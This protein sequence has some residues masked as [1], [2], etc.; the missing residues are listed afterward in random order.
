MKKFTLLVTLTLCTCW[1]NRAGAINVN[2]GSGGSYSGGDGSSTSP[3]FIED[4]DDLK[5]LSET[6]DDW[7]KYFVQTADIDASE[8]A[9]STYNSGKGFSPIGTDDSSPFSGSYNGKGHTVSNLYIN[10]PTTDFIG[11]FG[12][13]T[14]GKICNLGVKNSVIS[15]KQCVGALAGKIEDGAIIDSCYSSGSLKSTYIQC[16]GLVGFAAGSDAMGEC[17]IKNSYSTATVETTNRAGGFIGHCGCIVINCY[18]TGNAAASVDY[19]GG[20][21]GFA[22]G[23][24]EFSNC[25]SKCSVDCPGGNV[26]GFVGYCCETAGG[27][28]ITNCFWDVGASGISGEKSGDG[29]GGATGKSTAE[30]KNLCT[31]S[32]AGWGFPDVWTMGSDNNGYPALAWQGYEHTAECKLFSGGEGSSTNPYKIATFDDLQYLSENSDYWDKYFIQTEDIDADTTRFLNIDGL[33][34]LGFDPIG[35]HN[36][37]TDYIYFTGSYNGKGHVIKNLYINRSS[38][39]Y[40]GLFAGTNGYIDSLGIESANITGGNQVGIMSGYNLHSITNCYV[41]GSVKGTNNVGGFAGID[42]TTKTSTIDTI[43]NCYSL[44]DVEGGMYVGGFIGGSSGFFVSKCYCTGSV[45]GTAANAVNGFVGSSSNYLEHDCYYNTETSN[46]EHDGGGATG[47]SDTEMKTQSKFS[48]WDFTGET[49]NGEDD[50]WS[51]ASSKNGG[52]PYLSWQTFESTGPFSGGDGSEADPFQIA[53]L[54]DLKMLSDSSQYWDSCFVQ[55]ADIDA[56]ETGTWDANN[57]DVIEGF[58]P[59]GVLYTDEGSNLINN[60]FT[61]SY[62]GKGHTIS[63]LYIN[64][65]TNTH[66]GLFGYTG[67][68]SKIDSLGVIG[69]DISS[70]ATINACF[71]SYAGGLAGYNKGT[72]KNCYSTGKISSV[73]NSTVEAHGGGLAG[74]NDNGTIE[75]CYSTCSVRASSAFSFPVFSGGLAGK[76]YGGTI[77]NCYSTGNV[78]AGGTITNVGGLVGS[79]SGSIT[80]SFYDKGTSGQT[81]TGKGEG[82]TTAEMLAK[83]TFGNWDFDNT[84]GIKEGQTYPAL[85]AVSNNAPFAFADS[86]KIAS[87]IS[88]DSVLN[89]DYDY[90]TAQEKLVYEII[91]CTGN[92][93]SI[94]D[95][96]Y[97]F[98]SDITDEACDTVYYRA[99]EVVSDTDTLWGS[100]AMAVISLPFS[101]GAGTEASPFQIATLSDLKYLSEHSGCWSSHF[102]QTADLAFSDEDFAQNGDFYNEGAGFSP[103]GNS[104]KSFTGS[105]NGDGYSIEKL[106]VNRPEASGTGLFG[107]TS[108]AHIDSLGLTNAAITGKDYTGCLVGYSSLSIISYCYSTGDVASTNR[109]VGGLIG[110]CNNNDTVSYCY[111]I[112]DVKGAT[113]DIGGLIGLTEGTSVTNGGGVITSCYCAG[114]VSSENSDNALDGALIGNNVFYKIYSSYWDTDICTQQ[115][116]GMGQ[117]YQSGDVTGLV[118]DSMKVSTSFVGWDFNTIWGIID[119]KTYPVL[120]AFENNA[121]FAF[122]DSFKVASSISLDS[123]LN[124][125][126]DYETAQEKLVYEIIS[127][128]GNYGSIA[129]SAY[130]FAAT[131]EDGNSDTIY[132]QV[133]EAISGGDTLWGNQAQAVVTYYNPMQLVFVTTEANQTIKLP[134]LGEVNCTVDWGDGSETD[135]FTTTGLK[136]HTFANAGTYTVEIS[137]KLTQFGNGAIGWD[138]AGYLSQI[139]T[140]GDLGLT[141]LSGACK[142][143][144]SLKSVPDTLP[145]TVTSLEYTFAYINQASITNLD[146][147]K[148]NNVTSMARMFYEANAFN[149]D[150]SGWKTGAVKNMYAMFYYA[151]AFN[152]DIGGWDVSKVENMAWML[153]RASVFNR[154]ISGWT[155]TANTTMEAMFWD[156]PAF[157]Q[158]ISGW[159]VGNVTS[160]K[161]M[162]YKAKSF[163]QNIGKWN[164]TSVTDMADMF[165]GVTLST[166]NYDSLLIGW[167]KQSVQESVTFHGGSSKYLEGID[168][169]KTLTDTYNWTIT[170][171][172]ID[173]SIVAHDTTVYLDSA[174]IAELFASDLVT[175][176]TGGTDTILSTDTLYCGNV[177]ISN[178]IYVTLSNDNGLSATDSAYVDVLDTIVPELETKTA[179]TAYAD[180]FGN[181]SITLADLVTDTWD[182]CGIK[183]TTLSKSSFGSKDLGKNN[184]EVIL[185][186]NSGNSDTSTV[187]VTVKDTIAPILE[188]DSITVYLD[189]SGL[190][191]I[192]PR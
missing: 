13:V 21:A 126:Y 117:D 146:K 116:S 109:Y 124:N 61:G 25:Y 114:E 22:G 179:F 83:A 81:D 4:L 72:I 76:N 46:Q 135:D 12:S 168:A 88:L 19:A 152:Q 192:V 148:T 23:Y 186:D 140:F 182:N 57:D 159:D 6:P 131:V 1:L 67:P 96:T 120:K 66:V 122:A 185:F 38:I 142:D 49:T 68:G 47:L 134:L 71:S 77:E 97:T 158:D 2:P 128:T 189:S 59:I 5:K 28:V 172:G 154:D 10:L 87:S 92:Y 174:G 111:Y 153:A 53:N 91:G 54:N 82:K 143:A 44:A 52:Y 74:Y 127:C 139:A 164:I 150:I 145:E 45:T 32:G 94:S 26:N 16:G 24:S 119:G 113:G 98:N 48:N 165:Y 191:S 137:G 30:M 15:G 29:N 104:S 50:I 37:S 105:Y 79:N 163:D 95:K 60:K 187:A 171:G 34:T 147:W 112:G 31:Y 89:N 160:M 115:S 62:N 41:S 129:D 166:A 107:Y 3:Y 86:F 90:E 70:L 40:I 156:S 51:I 188:V 184:V 56:S 18:A 69:A 151:S 9:E 65:T 121:P 36:T 161:Q 133:G 93:G 169:R 118:T 183:E 136:E 175:S 108:G 7:G 144:D 125:D 123:L 80:A 85:K 110:C 180:S 103:I 27:P 64:S 177:G 170:D 33:D 84:W 101:A 39:D 155:T 181:A 35:Y 100:Q 190:A 43:M 58:S 73:S 106:Y 17:T 162:F 141:S 178:K 149:Q 167:A 55:T 132:Y 157:D 11:M 63:G 173:I 14:G 78:S 42:A 102:I 138:G 75:N 130:S 8:T 176:S 99:G 20:F